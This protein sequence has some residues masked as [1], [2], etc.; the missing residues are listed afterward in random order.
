MEFA[1]NLLPGATV[2]RSIGV[3]CFGQRAPWIH[4]RFPWAALHT[5]PVHCDL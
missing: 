2:D 1:P 4:S 3:V 5:V